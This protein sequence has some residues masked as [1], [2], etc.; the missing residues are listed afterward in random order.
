MAHKEVHDEEGLSDSVT[1][2]VGQRLAVADAECDEVTQE[3]PLSDGEAVELRHMEGNAKPLR[4]ELAR[5]LRKDRPV[6]MPLTEDD[7]VKLGLT[8]L[9]R[10]TVGEALREEHEQE[11]GVKVDTPDRDVDAEGHR[12]PEGLPV[13]ET[14]THAEEFTDSEMVAV[15]DADMKRVT[16]S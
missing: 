16:V 8:E 4:K 6:V 13:I 11:L 2:A 15:R 10:D 7:F 5:P 9:E 3:V 12:D 14:D 1:E